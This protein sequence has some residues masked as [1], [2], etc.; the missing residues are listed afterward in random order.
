MSLDHIEGLLLDMDGVLGVS[1]S[2]CRA[3]RT[4]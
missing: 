1:W 2:R 3:P 4:R